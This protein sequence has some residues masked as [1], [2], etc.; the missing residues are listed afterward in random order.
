MAV[1]VITKE[2]IYRFAKA[3]PDWLEREENIVLGYVEEEPCATAVLEETDDCWIISWLWVEPEYRG[4]GIGTLM[5]E[6][7]CKLATQKERKQIRIHYSPDKDWTLMLES[8]LFKKG[9]LVTHQEIPKTVITREW[10]LYSEIFEKENVKKPENAHIYSEVPQYLIGEFLSG[11]E[12]KKRYLV[13]RDC[14]LRADKDLSTVLIKDGKIEGIVLVEKLMEEGIYELSLLY[15]SPQA[16]KESFFFLRYTADV[17]RESVKE[18]KEIHMIC[19]NETAKRLAA[20]LLNTNLYM[21]KIGEG[22]LA[23]YML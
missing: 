13:D 21:S 14:V 16:L 5:L 9:F 12:V 1:E 6:A 11:C 23:E 18:F 3:L 17:F 19:V 15:L 20:N 7:L 8:I 4:N 2:N 22:I 10:F